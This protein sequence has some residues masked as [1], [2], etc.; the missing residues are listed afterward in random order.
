MKIIVATFEAENQLS[1]GRIWRE[2]E[3]L[4]AKSIKTLSNTNHLK[5]NVHF[6]R[7]IKH[8]Y[9]AQRLLDNFIND[10]RE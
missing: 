7:L 4:N 5:D 8:K 3:L 9:E 2:L 10:N 6:K 1:E